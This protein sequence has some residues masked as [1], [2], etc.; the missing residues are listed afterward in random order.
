L[1]VHLRGYHFIWEVLD[2]P[3]YMLTSCLST[4]CV[5]LG[6]IVDIA[7]IIHIGENITSGRLGILVE[8]VLGNMDSYKSGCLSFIP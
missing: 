5:F 2:A 1:N 7:C 4:Y 3:M 6:D 8:G